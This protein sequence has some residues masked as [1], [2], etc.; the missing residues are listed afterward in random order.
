MSLPRRRGSDHPFLA[1]FVLSLRIDAASRV[2]LVVRR[3]DRDQDIDARVRQQAEEKAG[4]PLAPEEKD[5]VLAANAAKFN[6]QQFV[7]ERAVLA[8][9]Q[10]RVGRPLTQEEKRQVLKK[11]L[12]DYTKTQPWSPATP[13]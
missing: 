8:D 7:K 9:V 12:G 13:E 10:Q 3:L 2:G 6:Q 5:K 1:S 11:L 4:R